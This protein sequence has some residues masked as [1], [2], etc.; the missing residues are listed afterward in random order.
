MILPLLPFTIIGSCV[1][2]A[3]WVCSLESEKMRGV[4]FRQNEEGEK[5]FTPSNIILF[6]K[7]PF[8]HSF[9]WSYEFLKHNWIVTTVCGAMCGLL[10]AHGIN[11]LQ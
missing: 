10:I 8:Q 3:T 4:I 9:F 7:A 6:M 5:I 2:F 1:G 11:F